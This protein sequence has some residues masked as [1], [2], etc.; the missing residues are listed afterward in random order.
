MNSKNF[1]EALGEINDRYIDEAIYFKK[2]KRPNKW[3]A[4]GATAACLATVIFAAFS[5]YRNNILNQVVI[6]PSGNIDTTV[7]SENNILIPEDI[8]EIYVTHIAAGQ[9]ETYM[10]SGTDLEDLKKWADSLVYVSIS[11][12]SETAYDSETY[13]FST[14]DQH[15]MFSYCSN[16]GQ[17][18]W[19]LIIN[20]SWYSVTNPTRPIL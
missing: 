3:A 2:K 14:E 11:A 15:L 20:G 9:E 12:P 13:N 18:D 1:S 17:N 5:L 7:G 4:L 8:S 10:L 16:K 6:A 19:Y